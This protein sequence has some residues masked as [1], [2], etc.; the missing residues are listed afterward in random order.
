MKCLN[1][2]GDT[3]V[4]DSRTVKDGSTVRRRKCKQCK[5]SGWTL[6]QYVDYE[7]IQGDY[8]S[9]MREKRRKY[10]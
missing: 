3:V 7:D 4:V 6:E 10:R 8:C 9:L 2:D 1:C 5:A